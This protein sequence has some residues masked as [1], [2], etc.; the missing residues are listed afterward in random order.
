MAVAYFTSMSRADSFLG[1][2]FVGDELL[3]VGVVVFLLFAGRKLPQ[4]GHGIQMGLREFRA[5]LR[6]MDKSARDAGRSAGGIFG[7]PAHEALTPD[8]RTAELYDPAALHRARTAR[9]P[10]LIHRFS[11]FLL[12]ACKLLW[13]RLRK[14]K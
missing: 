8:N 1:F 11:R 14:S 2:I 13:S 7:K 9:P 10:S 6:E 3:L 4:I 5:A 12:M